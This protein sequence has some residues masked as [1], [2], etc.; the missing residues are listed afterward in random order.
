MNNTQFF[1]S[2]FKELLCMKGQASIVKRCTEQLGLWLVFAVAVALGSVIVLQ[3]MLVNRKDGEGLLANDVRNFL[4]KHG[5][6]VPLRQ[7]LGS[8]S[9]AGAS[10]DLLAQRFFDQGL[11][12][13]VA[14]NFKKGLESF[15]QSETLD[16]LCA[17]CA[18]GEAMCRGQNLNEFLDLSHEN[19]QRAFDAIERAKRNAALAT[20]SAEQRELIAATALR[21][22]RTPE[23]MA[24]GPLREQLNAK[25]AD[26][27]Q[28]LAKRFAD[29]DWILFFA[30]DA[31]MVCSP[32][33]FVC[34]VFCFSNLV[35]KNVSPW[36]YWEES[37]PG[38]AG[39]NM[40][41]RLRKAEEYVRAVLA[42]SPKHAGALHLEIHLFE[43]AGDY[44]RALV[45]AETLEKLDLKGAGK[46]ERESDFLF[47]FLLKKKK[48]AE[49]LLHMPSHAYM[50]AGLYERAVQVNERATAHRFKD[51]AT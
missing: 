31:Q 11:R 42:R 14:Y 1:V 3:G 23:E 51:E 32:V 48:G 47:S 39:K 21:F 49:H 16:S 46:K 24:A 29:N 36:N 43:A 37:L 10:S 2:S 12:W 50:R 9:W 15:L 35:L 6:L 7:D 27:M 30:A 19:V 5:V 40:R 20:L 33:S 25:Y 41:P 17:M 26:A 18:W 13:M 34:F 44:D 8:S 22:A 28:E 38:G 4:S 45:A